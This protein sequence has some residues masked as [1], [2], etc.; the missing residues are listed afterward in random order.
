MAT[1]PAPTKPLNELPTPPGDDGLPVIGTTLA[2]LQDP[3]HLQKLREKHKT[4]MVYSRFLGAR[5]VFLS[6][7][8][9]HQW[10]FTGEDKYLVTEWN[11]AIIQILGPQGTSTLTGEAHRERRRLM[12]SRLKFESMQ[13]FAPAIKASAERHLAQWVAQK[14]LTVLPVMRSLMFEII[15]LFIFSEDSQ[16]LDLTYLSEQFRIA[17]SGLFAFPAVDLPFL[18]F[19]KSMRAK[20]NLRKTLKAHVDQRRN[21]GVRRKDILDT[22]LYPPENLSK[23]LSEDAI[24]DEL[25]I[26]LFAGHDT[27]VTALTN[28]MYWLATHPAVTDRARQEALALSE[29]DLTNIEVMKNQPYLEAVLMENLRIIPPAASMFRRIK[30]DVELNGYRI[31]K[32]WKVGISP[33]GSHHSHGNFPNPEKF[34][35]DRF[36][37]RQ[38]HKKE[39]F[40]YIPF[41]GGPRLCLGQNFAMTEMRIV[42]ALLLRN[43][44]WTWIEGQDSAF[45]LFPFPTMKSGV[46]VNFSAR[47]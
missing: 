16:N 35:P 38:E 12:Q 40:N 21:S 29:A 28:L 22:L 19:G 27:S 39:P 34:D 1:H 3:Q 32:G 10:A 24:L 8:T 14:P 37:V 42:L 17:D 20:G 9:A 7:S 41:G 2:F 30:E 6:G 5:T 31:P 18:P 47:T 13:D 26:L 15:A 11:S 33:R 25:Q 36:L 46:Q 44:E 43:Y 4:E 23:P 45:N